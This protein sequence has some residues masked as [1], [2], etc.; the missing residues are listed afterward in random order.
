MQK[1]GRSGQGPDG[2]DLQPEPSLRDRLTKA[3]RYYETKWVVLLG[4]RLLT[5]NEFEEISSQIHSCEVSRIVQAARNWNYFLP[6]ET[7]L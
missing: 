6:G 4:E 5:R 3:Y 1:R 2:P 7:P